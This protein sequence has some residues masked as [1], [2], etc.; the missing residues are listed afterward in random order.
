MFE[1]HVRPGGYAGGFWRHGFYF[2]SGA[3]GLGGS[4]TIFPVLR[5]MGVFDKIGLVRQEHLRFVSPDLHG[6]PADYVVAACDYKQTFQKL[7]D[8]AVVP[9]ALSSRLKQAPVSE[10]WV[11]VCL[12]LD[13]SNETV[14]HHKVSNHFVCHDWAK[15]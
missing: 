15:T 9:P 12:G 11:V 14:R 3:Y 2:E 6:T 1:S 4:S 7:L 13:T 5:Q 8:P 10:S